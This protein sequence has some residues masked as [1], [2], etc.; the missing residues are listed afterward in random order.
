MQRRAWLNGAAA[1]VSLVT[2]AVPM[3]SMRLAFTDA[4]NNPTSLTTR[5][6]TTCWPRGSGPGSTGRW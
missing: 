5:R 2:L 6:P 1:V 3:F 4:G